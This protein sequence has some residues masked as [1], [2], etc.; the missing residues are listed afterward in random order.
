M[1]VG[2]VG[3]DWPHAFLPIFIIFIIS[4]F[5]INFPLNPFNIFFSV[6]GTMGVGSV[7]G[8]TGTSL[9]AGACNCKSEDS[10]ISHNV[11]IEWFYKV[12]SPTSTSTYCFNQ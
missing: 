5:S 8:G 10:L 7:G 1:G 9:A 3:G 4:L 2:S 11:F 12:N 6:R